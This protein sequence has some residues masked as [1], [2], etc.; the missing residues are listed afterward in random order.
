MKI[1]YK[2]LIAGFVLGACIAFTISWSIQK[3]YQRYWLSHK[4]RIWAYLLDKKTGEVYHIRGNSRELCASFNDR[5][6][7]KIKEL[8]LENK[9]LLVSKKR[10]MT[11][12]VES[13]NRVKYL[14]QVS[15]NTK[16][17]K[18]TISLEEAYGEKP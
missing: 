17:K 5:Q 15:V 14:E 3:P 11:M 1:E 8:T 9:S 18:K 16:P 7:K 13:N 4:E 12:L 6:E 10:F 2:S